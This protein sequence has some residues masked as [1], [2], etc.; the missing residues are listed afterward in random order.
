MMLTVFTPTYNRAGYLQ[1]LYESLRRQKQ[2]DFEWLVVD[3]GSTDDTAQV[4]KSFQAQSDLTIRYV[5][6]ENGGKH[7]AY[8]EAL[9]HAR[10]NWFLCVDADD[11]L[12][13]DALEWLFGMLAQLPE[14]QGVAAYKS[15]QT[16]K[17][18]SDAFPAEVTTCKISDLSLRL[19]CRGEFTFVF[20][21]KVAREYPFP[22][23]PGEKFVG[24]NVVYDRIEQVCPVNLLG[25]VITVCEYLPDGYSQ[26]FG[27]LM[28]K[29]PSGFCVYFL[30]RI[31]LIPGLVGRWSCA[32]KY[33]C[34]RFISGNKTLKYHGP[35]K[36]AWVLGWPLGLAFRLYYKLLRGF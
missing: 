16:G 31:D 9:K 35:H 2:Q 14:D 29:N 20:P 12:S 18:L 7:T 19:N 23:F 15:D 32:G 27:G 5:C 22:E 10:G 25:Q 30:Q 17:T 13:D 11:Y 33:W 34:F 28:K 26:N 1:R 3:D 24:E 4:V 36:G 6:K 8:N 21:T